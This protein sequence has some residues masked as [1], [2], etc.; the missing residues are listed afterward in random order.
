MNH[1]V[2]VVAR[3]I[4]VL[5]FALIVTACWC[6]WELARRRRAGRRGASPPDST[7]RG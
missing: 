1:P 3:T 4:E 5:G 2:G 6:L 7:G